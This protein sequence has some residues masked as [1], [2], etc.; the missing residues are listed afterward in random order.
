MKTE[1][2]FLYSQYLRP[3]YFCDRKKETENILAQI[4]QNKNVL[5]VGR[6]GLGKTALIKHILQFLDKNGNFLPISV[7]LFKISSLNSFIEELFNS[8]IRKIEESSAKKSK[9]L[10]KTLFYNSKDELIS[11]DTLGEIELKEKITQYLNF[12]ISLNKKV[13][14]AVD[15]YQDAVRFPSAKFE[16][17]FIS[18]FSAD[19]N[20]CLLFSG[21]KKTLNDKSFN[22]VEIDKIPTEEYRNFIIKSFSSVGFSINEKS[23]KKIF[24]FSGRETSTTQL[25]CAKIVDY[26]EK[27]IKSKIVVNVIN[28][29]LLESR[30]KLEMIK[31][32]LSPYQWK[33]LLA[34]AAEGE[35]MFVTSNS[36]ISKYTLNA[37]SSVKT[38]LDALTDKELIY[39]SQNSY[40]ISNSLFRHCLK[41]N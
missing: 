9:K 30:P 6:N 26:G 40:F 34:I 31:Y 25:V 4:E 22:L 2:P 12:L 8:T 15:N 36:F 39:R 32:L 28:N 18:K 11:L 13:I 37:P 24:E 3:K 35:A 38:A 5:L 33:L 17:F 10:K 29:I 21:S 20:V 41:S 23:I 1:N 14:I 7:D 16:E 27:K 19:N